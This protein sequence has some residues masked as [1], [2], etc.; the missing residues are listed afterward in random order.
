MISVLCGMH[1]M[2]MTLYENTVIHILA[3]PKEHKVTP[4][5]HIKYLRTVYTCRIFSFQSFF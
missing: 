2:I 4:L 5:D 1:F 3:V